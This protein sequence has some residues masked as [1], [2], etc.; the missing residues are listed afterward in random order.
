M[1]RLQR[2]RTKL[3]TACLC[4]VAVAFTLNVEA[5]DTSWYQHAQFTCE[6][7]FSLQQTYMNGTW[8]SNYV[9]LQFTSVANELGY[10]QFPKS[11]YYYLSKH[12]NGASLEKHTLSKQDAVT[13]RTILLAVANNKVVPVTSNVSSAILNYIGA[14]SFVTTGFLKYVTSVDA[15]QSA[16]ARA[17]A[18]VTAMGGDL[19]R[20]LTTARNADG[21]PYLIHTFEYAVKVGTE[22]RYYATAS[23]TYPVKLSFS[24]FRTTDPA[25]KKL[26]RRSNGTTWQLINAETMV[27]EQVWIETDRDDDYLYFTESD[28]NFYRVGLNDGP[29]QKNVGGTWYYVYHGTLS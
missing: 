22:E 12:P 8:Y 1:L 15:S 2:L 9:D 18:E 10:V 16:T 4:L 19:N 20:V 27:A 29:I 23:C 11:D 14:G 26:L 6:D 24:E 21:K 5:K 25:N 7:P 3:R 28:T 17:L 13:L